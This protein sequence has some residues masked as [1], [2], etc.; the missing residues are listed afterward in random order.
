MNYKIPDGYLIDDFKTVVIPCSQ[1]SQDDLY[2]DISD[3]DKRHY[4]DEINE[5]LLNSYKVVK[6]LDSGD[7][8]SYHL[9]KVKKA[10]ND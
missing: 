5:A 4:I 6:I 1:G 10:S 9:V 8:V 2:C 3:R 7:Y